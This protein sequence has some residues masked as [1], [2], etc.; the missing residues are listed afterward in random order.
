MDTYIMNIKIHTHKYT[1]TPMTI[2]IGH[3]TIITIITHTHNMGH[4]T[5]H[6]NALNNNGHTQ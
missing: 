4:S 2:V 6:N 1:H 5:P 3:Y